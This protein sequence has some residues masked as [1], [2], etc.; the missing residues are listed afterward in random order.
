LAFPPFWIPDRPFSLT[1][2]KNLQV[3]SPLPFLELIYALR[4]IGGE[5]LI[6]DQG[7]FPRFNPK[8][9][10]YTIKKQ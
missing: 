5:P 6:V 3:Q 2:Q 10:S 9:L 8:G 7:R 1:P 4:K